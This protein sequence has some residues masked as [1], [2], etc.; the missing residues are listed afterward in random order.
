MV[1][2]DEQKK[3][4]NH[5]TC[6]RQ[7]WNETSSEAIRG[8]EIRACRNL[9]RRTRGLEFH[10]HCILE[11][12]ANPAET[13][14]LFRRKVVGRRLIEAALLEEC[15]ISECRSKGTSGS[16]ADT[17]QRQNPFQD[18]AET[19]AIARNCVAR[20]R[21][22]RNN[23]DSLWTN[24]L[25]SSQRSFAQQQDM[26]APEVHRSRRALPSDSHAPQ[27]FYSA[28]RTRMVPYF[29]LASRKCFRG[30][31]QRYQRE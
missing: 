21:L 22:G 3:E 28:D 20:R 4:D 16:S 23:P 13:A 29:D 10:D 12:L 8:D 7:E 19:R 15:M 26:K 17:A 14:L 31:S 6:K 24:S 1:P 9:N 30:P 27:L 18:S 11:V 5:N 2:A 25:Q